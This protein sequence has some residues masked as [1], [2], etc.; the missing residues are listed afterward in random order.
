M[1]SILT[2]TLF[3]LALA[4]TAMA[5]TSG[6]GSNNSDTP[7][8]LS[9]PATPNAGTG[10]QTTSPDGSMK[11]NKTPEQADDCMDATKGAT[12]SMAA[13]GTKKPDCPAK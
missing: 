12:N 1:K 9:P 5:Q 8:T 11:T 2:A 4:T 10:T 7:T 13:D 6:S 3:S